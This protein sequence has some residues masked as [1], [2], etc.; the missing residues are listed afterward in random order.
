MG[1]YA[2]DSWRIFG[3]DKLRG[4]ES[5]DYD[6]ETGYDNPVILDDSPEPEWTR[7]I[8]EDK[9]LRKWMA[10]RWRVEGHDYDILTGKRKSLS[11]AMADVSSEN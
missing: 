5:G 6:E 7:V 10:Q 1:P 4:I 3:R 11:E 9:D 2:I 8:P